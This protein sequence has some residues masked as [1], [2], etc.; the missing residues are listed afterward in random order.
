MAGN[1]R[2]DGGHHVA[3]L[4]A[5]SVQIAVTDA[6]VLDFYLYVV[7][8]WMAPRDALVRADYASVL[9]GL[10]STLL[11]PVLLVGIAPKLGSR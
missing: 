7:F 1:A 11:L 2:A 8:G 9:R 3:P 4:V 6:A 10:S 5:D